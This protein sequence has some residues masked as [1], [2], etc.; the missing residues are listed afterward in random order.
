MT[1]AVGGRDLPLGSAHRRTVLAILAATRDQVV[2]RDELIDALWGDEPPVSATGS[3]HTYVSSLRRAFAAV[4]GR[5]GR[6]ILAS[7]GAGY[8]L[9]LPGDAV[10]LWL[11]DS[12]RQRAEQAPPEQ[13]AGL[14]DAA[15]SLWRGEPLDGLPGPFAEAQRARLAELRRLCLE[16][17]DRLRATARIRA[18]RRRPLAGRR[19]ELAGLR[20]RL[21][22]LEQGEGGA[23]VV[24]G[25][26]GSGKSSLLAEAAAMARDRGV[27]VTTIDA[28]A[29]PDGPVLVIAD[30]LQR[31]GERTLDRWRRLAGGDAGVLALGAA[32]SPW[33]ADG[34]EQLQLGPL[35]GAESARLAVD[36]F[37]AEP[38]YRLQLLIDHGGGNPRYVDRI[39]REAA[40]RGWVTVCG[41]EARL[42][43]DVPVAVP[44]P[45]RRIAGELDFLPAAARDTLARG[46]LLG[47]E[48]GFDEL[49]AATGLEPA[50]LRGHVDHARLAGVIIER[51]GQVAFRHPVVYQ[52]CYERTPA[53]LRGPSH[54]QLAQ[55][56]AESGAPVVRVAGQLAAAREV[57]RWVSR[58]LQDNLDDVLA[59]SPA[60]AVR[61][62]RDVLADGLLDADVRLRLRSALSEVES[63]LD[64]EA[65]GGAG[66]GLSDALRD[67][68]SGD[69]AGLPAG[70][71]RALTALVRGHQ[72]R[73]EEAREQLR[74]ATE[75][76]GPADTDDLLLAATAQLAEQAGRPQE[77]ADVLALLIEQRPLGASAHH[78]LPMLVRLARAGGRPEL[79]SRALGVAESSG[80]TPVALHCRGL[81]DG[82]PGT[83]LA[84][85]EA[86][87][88][89]GH[90][91]EEAFARED[92]AEL[93]AARGLRA[94]ARAALHAALDRYTRLG[95]AW[96][97]RRATRRLAPY[98]EAAGA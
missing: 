86:H 19:A 87:A 40:E 13:A 23:V 26:P 92:A 78:W 89:F 85:A 3:V 10:D 25:E 75:T 24:T 45:A 71:V 6:D 18:P 37:G 32:R 70:A 74:S 48:F 22:R 61:L 51:G 7:T 2:S 8:T 56:L 5:T 97:V 77:A 42:S 44:A 31:A 82:D 68:W 67:Y 28:V 69:W 83:V 41:G 16:R 73:P 12:L 91:L 64:G 50:V 14:L 90:R 17:R 55:A 96:D 88:G 58:W 79:V 93:L 80:H 21:T 27:R 49:L 38:D 30:D 94:Q 46:A 52:A 53:A 66:H 84:A 47:Q 54:R 76:P 4:P 62:L 35:S 9:R 1:A 15:L 34:A 57:D 60:L 33:P 43:D 39:L 36:R 65:G 63:G 81:A 20:H 95:A 98:G 11:F 72:G 29:A 59:A